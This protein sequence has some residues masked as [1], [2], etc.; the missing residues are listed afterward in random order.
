M[1]VSR[2]SL[3][4]G[5]AA[6][7]LAPVPLARAGAAPAFVACCR[8]P[9]GT[10]AA[11]VIAE[12][13]E[14]LFTGALDHRGHD[15]AVAPDGG[16]AVVFER[17]P[18]RFGVVLDLRGRR[19]AAAFAVP[20]DRRLAGHG[21]FSADGRLLYAAEEDFGGE[22]GVLGVYDVGAGYRRIGEVPTH[23][24]GPHEALLL[25]DG[26]TI[27]VA[28]G[29]ILTH[30]A[31]PR[32]KLNLATMEPSFG[33]IDGA[34]GDLLVKESLPPALHQLSIRHMAP[35]AGAVWFA[36]QY[37]GPAEDLVPLVGRFTAA[38][39]LSLLDADPVVWRA[40]DQYVGAI[41]AS[42]DGARVAVTTRGGTVTEW[43]VARRTVASVRAVADP[44]GIAPARRRFVWTSGAGEVAFDDGGSVASAVNWDNHVRAI[45]A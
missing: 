16:T 4:G 9:G 8:T 17:R 32:Q 42:R 2:R 5:L 14:V 24:V 21:F 27:A 45:R 35:V 34:T 23:G 12:D 43:D 22:R 10:F 38:E 1:P 29:G 15:C 44:G 25:A 3:L 36:G 20:D 33:L 6:L 30:P 28:N 18:G 19:R 31:F 11:A 26:R 41:A 40:M 37:E 13:G 7:A 39:G